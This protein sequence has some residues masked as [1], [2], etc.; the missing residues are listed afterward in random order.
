M[1]DTSDFKILE[2][3]GEIMEEYSLEDILDYNGVTEAEAIFLLVKAG[4]LELPEIKPVTV[5]SQGGPVRFDE[6]L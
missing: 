4:Q 1:L 6:D 5:S 2:E 3:I